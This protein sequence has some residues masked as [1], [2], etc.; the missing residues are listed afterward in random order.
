MARTHGR[1]IEVYSPDELYD[2]LMQRG[3]ES[4]PDAQC[5]ASA[6]HLVASVDE[7]VNRLRG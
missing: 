7:V 2:G 5:Y 1:T 6:V 3:Y 4:T